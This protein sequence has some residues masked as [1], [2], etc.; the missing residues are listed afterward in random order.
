MPNTATKEQVG[1]DLDDM[2]VRISNIVRGS[3]LAVLAIG[4]GFLVTPNERVQIS[5]GPVLAA[6][7]FAFF[8]LLLDWGQYLTGYLNSERT[9]DA[10]EKDDTL[11]GWTPEWLRDA[12]NGLFYAKQVVTALGV[13]VL[14]AAIIP[15]IIRIVGQQQ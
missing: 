12:R 13:F 5:P 8:A 2:S 11:R 3:A 1:K 4:W 15:A 6:I 9:W 7:V 10:M 14:V